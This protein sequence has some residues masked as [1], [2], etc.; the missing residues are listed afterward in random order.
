MK[1]DE[2]VTRND[3]SNWDKV[4]KQ[5][6]DPMTDHTAWAMKKKASETYRARLNAKDSSKLMENTII[7][8]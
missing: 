2:A 7:R 3:K 1:Y 6:H 4:E 8:R 5:E